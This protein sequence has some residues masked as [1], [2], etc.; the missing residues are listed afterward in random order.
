MAAGTFGAIIGCAVVEV[1][2]S[3]LCTTSRELEGSMLFTTGPC[4][5]DATSVVKL[6]VEAA[7]K[8]ER[9]LVGA[10][11]VLAVVEPAA[12]AVKLKVLVVDLVEEESVCPSQEDVVELLPVEEALS[13]AP[14]T[15]GVGL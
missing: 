8:L 5:D 14:L 9:K 3:L 6:V 4:V 15:G 11:V 2:I 13:E 10:R 7:E 1:G 12:A